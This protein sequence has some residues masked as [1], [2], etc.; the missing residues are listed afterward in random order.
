M[1]YMALSSHMSVWGGF[2]NMGCRTW[3]AG[4]AGIR[5]QAIPQAQA[6]KL[7]RYVCEL[8]LLCSSVQSARLY[9]GLVV[10][11]W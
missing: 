10:K 1:N 2:R 7:N 6:P 5:K 3:D 4:L 8:T 11:G 9:F